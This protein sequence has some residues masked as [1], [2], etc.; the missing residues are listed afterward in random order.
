MEINSNSG[1]ILHSIWAL[2]TSGIW[3]VYHKLHLPSSALFHLLKRMSLPHVT[4]VY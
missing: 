3:I 1:G 2:M 4:D